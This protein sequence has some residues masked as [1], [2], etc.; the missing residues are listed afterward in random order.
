MEITLFRLPFHLKPLFKINRKSSFNNDNNFRKSFTVKPEKPNID[1]SNNTIKKKVKKHKILDELIGVTPEKTNN[2]DIN[3][4]GNSADSMKN[5]VVKEK[6]DII[7]NSLNFNIPLRLKIEIN[8]SEKCGK[9]IEYLK[10]FSE[11]NLEKNDNFTNFIM[12]SK[13]N[14]IEEDMTIDDTF[15]NNQKIS[16]YELLNNKGIKYIFEYEDLPTLTTVSLKKQKIEILNNQQKM[17]NTKVYKY[18]KI[19]TKRIFES[20]SKKRQKNSI[21]IMDLNFT[22]PKEITNY[23]SYEILTP[24]IHRYIKD[25]ISSKG[26]FPTENFQYIYDFFDFVIL[27]TKNAIKAIN[28]YE[29]MWEKYMYFLNSPSKFENFKFSFQI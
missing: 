14:Y 27:T 21:R 19:S 26:L 20:S 8:R 23:D 24:I 5:M 7:S 22:I 28:L 3:N 4:I 11:L 16:I 29:M 25:M 6:D 15:L 18:K 13:D 9:I 1:A 12:L 2:F 10:S 17:V